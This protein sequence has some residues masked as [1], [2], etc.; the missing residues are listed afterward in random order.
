MTLYFWWSNLKG[1]EESSG[2]A[3]R[4]MQITTVMVVV[5][6]IWSLTIILRGPWNLPPSPIPS[7]LIFT[8]VAGLVER[9]RLAYD[10]YCGDHDCVRPLSAFDERL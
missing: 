8:G 10:P 1:I 3:L 6:L 9:H 7:D 4:I 5:L 2:Q